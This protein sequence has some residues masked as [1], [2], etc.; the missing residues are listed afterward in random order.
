VQV[1]TTRTRDRRD[2]TPPVIIVDNDRE[3]DAWSAV[4]VALAVITVVGAVVL[5]LRPRPPAAQV[6]ASLRIVEVE[7]GEIIW[8]AS[9][10][11]RGDQRSVQALADQREDRRRMVYDISY[12]TRVLCHELANTLLTAQ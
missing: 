9:D 7:S 5:L 1:E 4:L 6:G 10:N 11:F 12:L 8:Q 2:R 3:H